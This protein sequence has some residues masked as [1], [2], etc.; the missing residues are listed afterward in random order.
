MSNK[1]SELYNFADD[2][3]R[4][5]SSG[6]LSQLIKDLQSEANKAIDWFKMNNMIVN[7]EKPHAII[8]DKE[9]QNNNPTEIN[10][11]EKKI[12]SESSVLLLGL[13]ID[14]KLNFDKHISKLCNKSAGQLNAFNRLNRYLGF[15][16]KKI[17]INSFIYGNFN[18]CPLVWHVCS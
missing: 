6:T 1:N 4:T 9:G 13:E 3:T 7:P 12:S 2:K 15:E 18:Y 16:E 17:V 8:I 14:S 5:S 11:D 10:I